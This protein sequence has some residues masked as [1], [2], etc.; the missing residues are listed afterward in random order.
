M[1]TNQPETI[2]NHF[3]YQVSHRALRSGNHPPDLVTQGPGTR[4][5]RTSLLHSRALESI[6]RQPAYAN[7]LL[8]SHGNHNKGSCSLPPLIPSAYRLVMVLLHV[9]LLGMAYSFLLR[10]VSSK[11]SFQWQSSPNMLAYLNNKIYIL[12]Q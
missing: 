1:Q 9:A 5:L 11:L 10:T 8:S 4:Q 6:L 3:L 12:K 2:P 7:L